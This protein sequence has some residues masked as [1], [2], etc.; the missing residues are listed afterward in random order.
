M[1]RTLAIVLSLFFAWI[2]IAL[3]AVAANTATQAELRQVSGIEP[4]I[5]P[6][7]VRERR[8]GP[9]ANIDDLRQRVKGVGEANMGRMVAGGLTV[10]GGVVS[11]GKSVSTA[12]GGSAGSEGRCVSTP[13][14]R[15]VLIERPA[16]SASSGPASASG[17]PASA[18]GGPASAGGGPAPATG[19]D[20]NK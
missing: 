11:E 18:S 4:A 20:S 8:N 13:V 3:A 5:A 19:G 12:V 16:P 10:G 15:G 6:R 17:G 14:G 9:Y 2:G 7:I 1:I